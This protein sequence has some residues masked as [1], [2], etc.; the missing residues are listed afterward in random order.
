MT[1]EAAAPG[2]PDRPA[3]G[4]VLVLGAGQ[5]GAGIA[6]VLALAGCRVRLHDRDDTAATAALHRIEH[7]RYGMRAAADRGVIGAEQAAAALAAIRPVAQFAAACA[8]TELVIEAVTENLAAK[9]AVFRALDAATPPTAILASNS[10]GFPVAALA[11]ATDRPQLVLG[12]HW[13]SPAPVMR[14]AEI[15]VHDTCD[16]AAVDTVVGLARRCGKNP[17]VVRDDATHWGFVPNRIMLAVWAEA[18]RIVSDGIATAAQV[19]ALVKDCFRWPAGPFEMRGAGADPPPHLHAGDA[20]TRL[21]EQARRL[22]GH[23]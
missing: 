2:Q 11:A 8:D 14:L 4:E 19:D 20:R 23:P 15:V 10:S 7:G 5:M 21:I 3:L 22:A 13:A 16:P 18:D 12:W 6:Q 17:Q 1:P 9:I